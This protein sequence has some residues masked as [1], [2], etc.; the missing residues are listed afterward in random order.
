MGI[1]LFFFFLFMRLFAEINGG[2][3]DDECKASRCSHH[4]P[5]IRFPFRLKHQPEH[6]GYPE[7]E[8]SCSEEK[9]TI[10][11]L[12]SSGKLWVK[13][14]NYTSQ[15]IY[16]VPW[17]PRDCLQWQILNFNLSGSPFQFIYE[18]RYSNFSFFNCSEDTTN[19]QLY[20]DDHQLWSIPCSFLSSNPVYVASSYN[21]LATVNLS[22][23]RKIFNATLPD[24][25]IFNYEGEFYM[26]W[27]KPMCGNCEAKGNKC[28]RKKN[29]SREPEIE[30]IDKPA[31]GAPMDKM[32]LT[33]AILGFLHFTFGIFIIF[34][35]YRSNK[36]KREHRINIQK[37]LED[38]RA[39]KPS[40]YSY[41]DIKKITN[42]FKDK[43]GQGGYGTVYKGKLSNE[44]F[45]AVKILDDFKGNGEDFINEVGTMST[46]HH[47][48][49][50][51]L[52][53]FCADGYKRALIYEF[54]PNESLDKFIFSAF[55][56]N[57]SLGWHKLQDIAIGIA[58]GIEYLHQGCDQ[59]IL[60]LDIKPH[61]ILLDHNFNP[62]ISDFGLAKLCS[63]EQSAVSMTAARGTMG[64]IAP[65]MLSRNFGNVSSKSDVYSFGMLLIEMVGGRKNI[66]ATVE[67]TSQAYFPEWLYNHLDQEQ[68]V[69]IRIEDESDI[70][71]AKKLSIIGLW[72]IQWYP[73]DRPSMKI[74]V[75]MLE[76]EEGNLVMPP[77]P[78]TS[79][80]QTRTS[81][82]RRKTSIQPELTVISE[83]E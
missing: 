54:L 24:D 7:F 8:L 13:E 70:K 49:V 42:N 4:G 69:H 29:N 11:E 67:N 38:Y 3:R 23:C 50:V 25:V 44:V 33:E 55:G 28:Q 21:A 40:R 52:L 83:I 62:K 43:L 16:L 59:R 35:V 9:R 39:L 37:F 46:I 71:I 82:R 14:I 30:C 66:D 78:F 27:S 12:P 47:V 79:M 17:Y 74:V 73:I 20:P 75:G 61:N 51:R 45:V 31:K 58:K 56:N 80:G 53:G 26:N 15:E 6:C 68:E 32:V 72:C 57:Y 81:V 1:S 18:Y 10:L 19:Q 76:G 48:N 34:I 64:Y 77:N 60:H 22:S 41:A 2:S 36:L 5:V 65:E 63:K